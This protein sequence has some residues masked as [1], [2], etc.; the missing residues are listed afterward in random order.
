M[1]YNDEVDVPTLAPD[2]YREFVLPYELELA[3]FHAGVVYWHSCGNTTAMMQDIARLPRIELMHISPWAD[4]DRAVS[5]FPRTTALDVD[6]HTIK[7]V[8][9]AS[10]EQ[11]RERIRGIR[12]KC[13]GRRFSIRADG[14][15][16][17]GD[18]RDNLKKIETWVRVAR[19]ETKR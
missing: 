5:I 7:D 3:E 16:V 8:Y 14:F 4:L 19:E 1:L 2:M 10:E 11:M 9:E 13:A 15:Q 12:R 6:L 18:I 17:M